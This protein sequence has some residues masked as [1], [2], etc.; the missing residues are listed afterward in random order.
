MLNRNHRRCNRV[1]SAVF[2]EPV[3]PLK[4]RFPLAT[5]PRSVVYVYPSVIGVSHIETE[6][7][8]ATDDDVSLLFPS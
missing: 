8:P 3:P 1:R 7:D 2:A 5:F 4:T 6:T